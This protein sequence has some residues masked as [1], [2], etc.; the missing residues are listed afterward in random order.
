[1]NEV[2]PNAVALGPIVASEGR[3]SRL[4]G[5]Y[6]R[7]TSDWLHAWYG[8]ETSKSPTRICAAYGHLLRPHEQ[9]PPRLAAI[10]PEV[11]KAQVK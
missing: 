11:A 7:P 5:D 1:M 4:C 6:G 9:I 10:Y 2:R 3:R 8:C